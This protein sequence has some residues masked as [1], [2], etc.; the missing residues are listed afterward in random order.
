MMKPPSTVSSYPLRSVKPWAV[1]LCASLLLPI[2]CKKEEEAPTPEV[3]VQA[4]HPEK[5][6][7]AEQIAA[8][9]ILAPL[10]QSAIS[11]KVTAPVKKFYVQRG[12]RVHAGELLA[13]LENSDLAGAAM[14][15]QGTY[16]AAQ[17]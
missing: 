7:I 3:Y 4:E 14:D 12:A 9:A 1:L 8:D 5:G 2:G 13:T 15:N 11:P 17:A 6:S 10:S 16:T